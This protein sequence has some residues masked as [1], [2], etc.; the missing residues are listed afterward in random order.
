M[1][2]ISP[3]ENTLTSAR[4]SQAIRRAIFDGH[5][6]PG[7][8]IAQDE[9][10]EQLGVSRMPIR[11]AL[12]QLAAEGLV[13]L[14]PRRGAWVAPLTLD[15]LDESYQLRTWL[16]PRAVELSV[17][18]LT[19][20][21]LKQLAQ[22]VDLLTRAERYND[23]ERFVETNR[24]FHETLRSRCPWIKLN[25]IVDML[26]NG[27]PPLTP[28]FVVQQMAEDRDEHAALLR[29][30]QNHDGS[31]AGRVMVQHIQRSALRAREYFRN[32]G[33]TSAEQEDTAKGG[34]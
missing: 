33:W 31:E 12:V 27:F 2:S 15:T 19:D 9:L 16:E 13:T 3:V 5:L 28:Q 23:A 21:D 11:E 7:H 10:A 1:D 17:A 30:A 6:R 8:K 32:M 18:R 34:S 25:G 24:E 29:A 22:Q 14:E 4:V 20:D 26:W